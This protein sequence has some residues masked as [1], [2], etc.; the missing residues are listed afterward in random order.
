MNTKDMFTVMKDVLTNPHRLV[1]TMK[2][3]HNTSND[4]ISYYYSTSLEEVTEQHT[5]QSVDKPFTG[6]TSRMPS[7]DRQLTLKSGQLAKLSSCD[8][9]GQATPAIGSADIGRIPEEGKENFSSVKISERELS[10]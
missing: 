5:R 6:I 1:V 7:G 4:E 8:Q 2:S 3:Q 10:Y 9:Q